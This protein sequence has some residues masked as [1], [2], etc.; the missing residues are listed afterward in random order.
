[1]VIAVVVGGVAGQA[2]VGRPDIEADIGREIHAVARG[3][4]DR[5]VIPDQLVGAGSVWVVAGIEPADG[6]HSRGLI[7]DDALVEL[8]R[9]GARGVV[10]DA[11][12]GAPGG[13]VVVGESE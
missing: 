12:G 10:V 2:G 1:G 6:D 11:N 8:G 4:P 13:A 9:L 3:F 7:D 5:Q